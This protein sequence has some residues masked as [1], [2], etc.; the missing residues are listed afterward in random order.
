MVLKLK[1]GHCQLHKP[2][3]E[4]RLSCADRSHYAYVNFP[5]CTGLDIL[6]DMICIHEPASLILLT[7]LLQGLTASECLPCRILAP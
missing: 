2:S 7:L 5:V 6:I 4:R 1:D 3:Y